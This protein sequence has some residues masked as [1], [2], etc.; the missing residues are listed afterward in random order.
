MKHKLAVVILNFNGKNYLEKFLQNVVLYSEPYPVIVA[1]NKSED[2]SVNYLKENF[3]EV[4]CIELPENYGYAEGY[5]Q[6]LRKVKAEY[7]VLLNNDVEVSPNWLTPLVSAMEAD[8]TL[9]ACQPKLLDYNQKT[10]FEYAGASG[11]FIDFLGYPFCRGRIFTALEEDTGQYNATMDVFW[12]SGACMMLRTRS[13]KEAGEFDGD[14]F[15]HMEEI[16]L[17]WRMKNL[18]YRILVIPQSEVFHVGGGTLNKQNPRKTF[19]NFRNSLLTL[20]KNHPKKGLIGKI[21]CRLMLD[22]VAGAR[23]L[24]SLQALHTLAILKAHISYYS[25]LG[26]T[27]KKR[28]Q[29]P[30]ANA[31]KHSFT[32]SQVYKGSIVVEYYISAVKKF[33]DL[34]KGWSA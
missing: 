28:K 32:F 17:C 7:F 13:F 5:N 24:F 33:S 22:G 19:L 26:E 20:T 15:A 11:G 16:D 9:A 21:V 31:E 6:A 8:N 4:Q 10:M 3:K 25:L 29:Q 14:Y 12:A 1:D 23:Y 2:D 27:L 18:G 30:L 34:K